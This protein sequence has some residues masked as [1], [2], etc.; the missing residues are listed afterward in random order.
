MV[1]VHMHASKGSLLSLKSHLSSSFIRVSM[2]PPHCSTYPCEACSLHSTSP[3]NTKF[4]LVSADHSLPVSPTVLDSF[5]L[6]LS[7]L[8]LGRVQQQY[9]NTGWRWGTHTTP[10]SESQPRVP[11]TVLLHS[12]SAPGMVSAAST[13]QAISLCLWPS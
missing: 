11:I 1:H 7:Q 10:S 3:Q 2:W 5:S 8:V 4:I 9:Y 12:H 6:H 13:T